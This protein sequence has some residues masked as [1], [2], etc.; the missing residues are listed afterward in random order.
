MMRGVETKRCERL[1][2]DCFFSIP[3]IVTTSKALVTRSD[4]LVTSSF[5]T[6]DMSTL[7]FT[8]TFQRSF[9]LA[10]FGLRTEVQAKDR[11]SAVHGLAVRIDT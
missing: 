6:H 3:N 9:T 10:L 4:A 7:D 11:R 2:D 1:Y 5:M 8:S